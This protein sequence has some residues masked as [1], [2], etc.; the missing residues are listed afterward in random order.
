MS[1]PRSS[2][3][4]ATAAPARPRRRALRA[5]CPFPSRT[6]PWRGR[7][8][9]RRGRQRPRDFIPIHEDD[10]DAPTVARTSVPRRPPLS[11]R[12]PLP[13]RPATAP[14]APRSPPSM[15]SKRATLPP[16]P[17]AAAFAPPQA[18]APS[19]AAGAVVRAADAA[20]ADVARAV[21]RGAASAAHA[22][23]ARLPRLAVRPRH[24]D[25]A[26]ADGRVRGA[27]AASALER[28]GPDGG[29][30]FAAGPPRRLGPRPHTTPRSWGQAAAPVVPRPVRWAPTPLNLQP[31]ETIDFAAD[32]QPLA[33]AAWRLG[34][35]GLV[36]LIFLLAHAGGAKLAHVIAARWTSAGARRVRASSK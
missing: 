9:L 3:P 29:G 14:Y 12:W 1:P 35:P 23:V 20:V 25:A 22:P 4:G 19:P 17:P 34:P 21:V 36:V 2:M 6:H 24:A 5:A 16:P 11:R 26:S 31:P 8:R 33:G 30:L 10:D 18:A 15:S 13:R 7:Q 27:H 32:A 28:A